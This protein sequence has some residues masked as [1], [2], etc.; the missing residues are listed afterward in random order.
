MPLEEKYLN[1]LQNWFPEVCENETVQKFSLLYDR[2]VATN[3]KIN[4]TS[5]LSP[6]DVTLKH[7]VDSLTLFLS[8]EFCEGIS[9]GQKICDVGCGGGFPG[10]PIATVC[11]EADLTMIDST[12]K[13]I[14]ALKENAE[15]LNLKKVTPLWGRG[16]ELAGKGGAHRE[17]YDVCVS[18]AV[19]RLPVLCELC[20]P[21][22]RPG[23][24]LIAMKGA[25]ALEEVE[26]SRKC[27][28]ALGGSLKEVKKID[29]NL[30]SE[31]L[32]DFTD[33]ER[34]IISEFL[35][36]ARYLVI[37]EKKKPTNP[38]YPRKWSQIVKKP[39]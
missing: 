26:D 11:P 22:V 10:L 3:E 30:S 34:K 28:P 13:K 37:I 12:E 23:G 35:E 16:E 7:F 21:F 2:V 6:I 19:A 18:R 9:A 38:I 15:I 29:L 24:F 8:K 17:R 5:L 32:A 4:I 1:L 33:D 31:N 27:I 14:V 25:K 39:L 36:S 20:L